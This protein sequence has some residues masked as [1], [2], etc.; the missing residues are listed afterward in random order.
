MVQ[1]LQAIFERDIKK[2]HSEIS[3][4]NHEANL[5]KTAPGILNSGGNLALHL[6]GNLNTYI[7]RELGGIDYVRDREAEFSSSQ[8]PKEMVLESIDQTLQRVQAALENLQDEQ[9]DHDF[10][11]I[12][13]DHPSTLGYTLIHLAAHLSYHLGQINYHRRLLDR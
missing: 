12:I 8:I 5:W 13:W 1:T 7:G 4:Y 2:L 3:L 9:L 6:V 10:P 11:I